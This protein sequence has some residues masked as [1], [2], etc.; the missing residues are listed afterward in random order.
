MVEIHT[1]V[2]NNQLITICKGNIEEILK[3]MNTSVVDNVKR[4]L[5]TLNSDKLT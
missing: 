1:D 5:M 2:L 3:N 4:L